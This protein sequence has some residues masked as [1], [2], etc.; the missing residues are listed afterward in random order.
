VIIQVLEQR[1]LD[2]ISERGRDVGDG[3]DDPAEPGRRADRQQHPVISSSVALAVD[4][5]DPVADRVAGDDEP[6]GHPVGDR[7]PYRT[8]RRRRAACSVRKLDMNAG[9]ERCANVAVL[10]LHVQVSR[11]AQCAGRRNGLEAWRWR[12]LRIWR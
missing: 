3:T 2:V 11:W 4:R 7:S 1:G 6:A 8:L 10:S 5:L 9:G 12:D